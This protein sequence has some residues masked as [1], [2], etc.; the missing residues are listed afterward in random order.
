MLD[1]SNFTTHATQRLHGTSSNEQQ[2][3]AK[4]V[5]VGWT[6]RRSSRKGCAY[7]VNMKTGVS[8]WDHP[9]DQLDHP[10]AT[11]N[12]QS[13]SGAIDCHD[14]VQ[15]LKCASQTIGHKNN[16]DQSVHISTCGSRTYQSQDNA[17]Q[18]PSGNEAAQ[19]MCPNSTCP[20]TSKVSHKRRHDE[21][22]GNR[23][24]TVLSGQ[25]SDAGTHQYELQLQS[26][27]LLPLSMLKI[28]A[29]AAASQMDASDSSAQ[30][31]E[32]AQQSS[33]DEPNERPVTESLEIECD[34]RSDALV[35]S[36]R[37]NSDASDQLI[38]FSQGSCPDLPYASPQ[39]E[40]TTMCLESKSN[41]QTNRFVREGEESGSKGGEVAVTQ[42][43]SAWTNP[44]FR[45]KGDS[46]SVRS[47]L[48]NNVSKLNGNPQSCPIG[49]RRLLN[50]QR[51]GE[52]EFLNI[53]KEALG[54]LRVI[55][56]FDKKIIIC[57]LDPTA[58]QP[59][60]SPCSS[61]GTSSKPKQ[62]ERQAHRMMVAIDQHAAD[63][64]VQLERL[65][66][67]TFGL[68]GDQMLFKAVECKGGWG[69]SRL[70][71]TFTPDEIGPLELHRR[72]LEQWGFAL[73]LVSEF[74]DRH[75]GHD[76][77][78]CRL[79]RWVR[80]L[81]EIDGVRLGQ[82]HLRGLL[83]QLA[84]K[85]TVS[86][87]RGGDGSGRADVSWRP[88]VIQDLLASRACHQAIR[89]GEVLT[90][91]RCA[92]LVQQLSR[93]RLPFQCAHGRPVLFPLGSLPCDLTSSLRKISQQI[94]SPHARA[95]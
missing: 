56:Q 13:D 36:M 35:Q 24:S 62:S 57:T 73:E 76:L 74:P 1:S 92:E 53:S 55:G 91:L 51:L 49:F 45:G 63:E 17:Q 2:H 46:L 71:W 54:H 93:C 82:Y 26:I 66:D 41:L 90:R 37:A 88:L 42:L 28:P 77:P 47:T 14:E 38:S 87:D 43:F 8:Q 34:S 79:M 67:A 85:N 32:N 22:G 29:F 23:S 70:Y 52:G 69:G 58:W 75:R 25:L 78:N 30:K 44:L 50:R 33:L 59:S 65:Q 5:P 89:F 60:A 61:D 68:D 84:S 40:N 11:R 4:P 83:H 80:S 16:P 86:D 20:G 12:H 10:T 21:I 72:Q 9:A 48:Q 31:A 64:R 15:I 3:R 6:I 7:Y 94:S 18:W 81:P 27:E 39:C 95:E 19:V